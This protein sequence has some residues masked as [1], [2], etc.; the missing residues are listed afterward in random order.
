M[1]SDLW[2]A[3]NKTYD[4][5]NIVKGAKPR[6]DECGNFWKDG[7]LPNYET[8]FTV[9]PEDVPGLQPGQCVRVKIVPVEEPERKDG[10]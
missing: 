2:A 3:R 5:I 1:A 8:L 9:T 4:E 6:K 7:Y 10:E